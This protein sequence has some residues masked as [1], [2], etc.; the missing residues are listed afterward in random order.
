MWSRLVVIAL[1][2][3][4][5]AAHANLISNGSFETFTGTFAGDGC[6]QLLPTS[7]TMTG[8][9]PVGA[10]I[11][12][13]GTPNSYLITASDGGNF[14]DIAGYQNTLNK[15]VS[16][17]LSGLTV[18]Q[19]YTFSADLG[20]SNNPGCVP[21]STCGGPI[22]VLVTIEGVSQ[23]LTHSS[24]GAGVQWSS[25]GITFTADSASP[26]LTVTGFGLPSNGAFIG[27]DN[28]TLLAAPEPALASLLLAAAAA[29]AGARLR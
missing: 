17:V 11:A 12:I 21:G 13:C 5:P 19:Q 26:T 23:V 27:L 2:L 9:T 18:G 15:G 10:E 24:S 4:G 29:L 1:A 7:T 16:Q 28:L 8:W 20:V 22:S 6:R 14:L 25:Y 3:A